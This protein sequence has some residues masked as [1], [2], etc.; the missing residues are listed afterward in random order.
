MPHLETIEEFLTDAGAG[1]LGESQLYRGPDTDQPALVG[2]ACGWVQAPVHLARSWV[3]TLGAP[4][5][6]APGGLSALMDP[7][8][9]LVFPEQRRAYAR[10]EWGIGGVNQEVEVDWRAGSSIRFFGQ[11]IRVRSVVPIG[12]TIAVPRLLA[13]LRLAGSIM[14]ATSGG[15]FPA[16]TRTRYLGDVAPESVAFCSVPP[17]ARTL[18]PCWRVANLAVPQQ[19]EFFNNTTLICVA[20]GR[21]FLPPDFQAPITLPPNTSVVAFRNLDTLL[22]PPAETFFDVQFVFGL[23]L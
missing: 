4:K 3:V 7:D 22:P 9:N 1:V 5:N 2:R 10:I 6:R 14:P 20:D 19:I 13:N 17:F 11:V 21:D 16:P 18:M 8:A 15:G 12:A 23:A